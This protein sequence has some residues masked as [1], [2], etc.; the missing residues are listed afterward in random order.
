[1]GGKLTSTLVG[2]LFKEPEMTYAS[3]GNNTA[4]T[5]FTLPVDVYNSKTKSN[6]TQWWR[7]V[8]FGQLAERINEYAGV[9]AV[10]S[11]EGVVKPVIFT[12]KDGTPALSLDFVGNNCTIITGAQKRDY[13]SAD[14]GS[15]GHDQDL[16][17]L[18]D[19][20]F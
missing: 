5:R 10:V 1:M 8:L 16:G 17:E 6:D 4:V 3:T 19:H 7:V 18:D 14:S 20:P 11:V 12:K 15:G 2:K 13:V 9:G